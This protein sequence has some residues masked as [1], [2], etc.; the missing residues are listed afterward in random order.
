MTEPSGPDYLDPQVEVDEL[1]AGLLAYWGLDEIQAA[2]DMLR[3]RLMLAWYDGQ[4]AGLNAARDD[5][6]GRP[7]PWLITDKSHKGQRRLRRR[8]E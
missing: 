5:F 7:N 4:S 1:L 8:G 3:R 2:R 6:K